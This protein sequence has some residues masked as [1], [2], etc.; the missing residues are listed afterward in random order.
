MRGFFLNMY[1]KENKLSS[2]LGVKDLNF[3]LA[4][5]KWSAANSSQN[6]SEKV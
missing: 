3:I 1:Y 4:I 2:L 5:K 6:P